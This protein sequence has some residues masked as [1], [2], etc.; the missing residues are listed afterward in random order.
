MKQGM[1]TTNDGNVSRRFFANPEIRGDITGVNLEL[2]HRF[3]ILLN[4]I[5][6]SK[7]IDVGKFHRYCMG[8][9]KLY[10]ELYG[11]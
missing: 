3:K 5:N 8:T 2:I 9:A 6:S 4:T 11:W 10:V 7:N 1:E